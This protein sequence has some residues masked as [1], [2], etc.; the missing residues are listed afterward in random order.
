MIVKTF[1]NIYQENL[2]FPD[3]RIMARF[4]MLATLNAIRY[5]FFNN[6]YKMLNNYQ[7]KKNFA[8]GAEYDTINRLRG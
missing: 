7:F 8:L 4:R 3:N 6:N 5:I 2:A 1:E